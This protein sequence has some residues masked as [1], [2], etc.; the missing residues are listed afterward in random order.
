[1]SSHY[2]YH[3]NTTLSLLFL[4]IIILYLTTTSSSY[5]QQQNSIVELPLYTFS[6]YVP[7]YQ[8]YWPMPLS[9]NPTKFPLC[10]NNYF[11][12]F[13]NVKDYLILKYGKAE[14]PTCDNFFCNVNSTFNFEKK[15]KL[16]RTERFL[17]SRMFNYCI[18]CNQ[19]DSLDFRLKISDK[20]IS[21][22]LNLIQGKQQFILTK[23]QLNTLQQQINNPNNQCNKFPSLEYLNFIMWYHCNAISY[24]YNKNNDIEIKTTNQQVK[25][26]I[27]DVMYLPMGIYGERLSS[28]QQQYYSLQI[29]NVTSLEEQL[30]FYSPFYCQ[31]KDNFNFRCDDKRDFIYFSFQGLNIIVTIFFTI[32]LILFTVLLFTPKLFKQ[33]LIIKNLKKKSVLKFKWY[34]YILEYLDIQLHA[35]FFA[36][37]S[38]LGF[39]IENFLKLIFN[40]ETLQELNENYFHGLFR[41]LGW[42]FLLK[43]KQSDKLALKYKIIYILFLIGFCIVM[44]VS[45][46]LFLTDKSITKAFIILAVV[47]GLY[48]T[49]VPFIFIIYGLRIYFQLRKNSDKISFMKLRLSKFMI[50]MSIIFFLESIVSTLTLVTYIGNWDI[51]GMSYGILRN[52]ILDILAVIHFS[53][54]LFVL[55]IG[56]DFKNCYGISL[57]N[58]ICCNYFKRK[59]QPTNNNELYDNEMTTTTNYER[60]PTEEQ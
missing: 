22:T 31:C 44:L 23:N 32:L 11:P 20:E 13:P 21:K 33:N 41:G 53:I 18:Y 30:K 57:R 43:V 10:N 38:I 15:G 8:Y 54:S 45:L 3:S 24:N 59:K 55:F 49:I 48:A 14:Y 4:T 19:K 39:F 52:G 42:V 29:I 17:F 58:A 35:P 16:A 46:I 6:D 9:F 50:A 25:A 27:H 7:Y 37:L 56:K 26:F 36:I 40:S 12:L 60:I 34:Q 47:G 28:L 1:M 51:L 2:L 5:Q